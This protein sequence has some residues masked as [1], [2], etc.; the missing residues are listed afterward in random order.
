M[1]FKCVTLFFNT[2]VFCVF[3]FLI[4]L[5][6]ASFC[7]YSLQLS[8]YCADLG[9]YIVSL[10]FGRRCVLL[11]VQRARQH[12]SFR[13]CNI[14]IWSSVTTNYIM[15][16]LCTTACPTRVLDRCLRSLRRCMWLAYHTRWTKIKNHVHRQL[17]KMDIDRPVWACQ[18]CC[19]REKFG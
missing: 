17:S 11:C 16:N 7:A 13:Q 4:A 3:Y 19:F 12:P 15:N 9:S 18:N 14:F 6:G 10:W 8:T 2:K 5:V 1:I